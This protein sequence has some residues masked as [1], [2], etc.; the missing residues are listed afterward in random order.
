[1]QLKNHLSLG[2]INFLEMLSPANGGIK[3]GENS[4]NFNFS[5]LN[6]NTFHRLNEGFASWLEFLL[7]DFSPLTENMRFK[8]HFNIRKLQNAFRS[9]SLA[10]TRPMTF[11][12]KTP[13]E[14]SARFDKI[15][16]DKCSFF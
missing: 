8:D 16:Y 6:V 7:P 15:A 5:S 10:T 12:A 11:D 9:D 4:Y 14:I 1:V 3:Y 13:A 2:L